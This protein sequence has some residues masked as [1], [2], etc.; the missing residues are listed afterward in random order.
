MGSLDLDSS[1]PVQGLVAAFGPLALWD[2]LGR[3]GTIWD[4]LGRLGA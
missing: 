4:A 2:A 3:P 1:G